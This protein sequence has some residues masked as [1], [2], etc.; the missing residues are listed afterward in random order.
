MQR[1]LVDLPTPDPRERALART[2]GVPDLLARVLIT[3]GYDDPDRA[4]LHLKPDLRRLHDPFLFAGMERAVARIRQ[5]MTRGERI[6]IHGD[7][8]VDGIAGSVL[9][10]KLL[11]LVQADVKVHIPRREDGYSFTAASLQAVRDGGFKLCISVDNGTNAVE[12][13]DA[14]QGALGCD[15]IV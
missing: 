6:M 15:V 4:R 7:Y 8:D 14:I 13:I 10:F 9:L 11:S 2:L 1:A 5:A 3:R 12:V